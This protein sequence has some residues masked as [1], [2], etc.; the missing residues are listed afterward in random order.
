MA[1][2]WAAICWSVRSGAAALIPATSRTKRSSLCCGRARSS[3]LASMMPSSARRRTVR[4]S[5]STVQV[6]ACPRF[7]TRTTSPHGWLGRICRTVGSQVSSR[8]RT[9]SRCAASR[10]PVVCGWHL[11]RRRAGRDCRRPGRVRVP[12]SARLWCAR[13]SDA[14]S[15]WAT[16]PSTCNENMPCGVEVSIGSRRLRKC[17][18]A[19]SSCSMTASRWL[20]ER[21]RRSSRTTTRVSPGGNVAQQARQHG[22]AAIGAGGVLFEDRG[23]T[24]GAQFVELRIR[25]LFVG[26]ARVADQA[27]CDGGFAAFWRRHVV[28]GSS[29]VRFTIQQG[30]CKRPLDRTATP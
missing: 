11:G 25:A 19:A 28:S 17:A 6:A 24:G 20:T 15:S 18:P 14:R 23:A 27:A 13:R 4:R 5:R 29:G 21:A 16:A 2:S 22:P 7:R 9:P 10:L 8:A 12:R 3:K 30:V 26:G 1:S